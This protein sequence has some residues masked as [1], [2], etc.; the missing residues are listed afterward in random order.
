MRLPDSIMPLQR[1]E[2]A[3]DSVRDGTL[4]GTLHGVF[5]RAL[6]RF[7]LATAV[8]L[9]A[10][11]ESGMRAIDRSTTAKLRA[12]AEQVGGDAIYP[13]IDENRYE[14]GSY[15]PDF[16]Q[17]ADRP[18]TENPIAADL[19]FEAAPKPAEDA[20]AIAERFQRL[21]EEDP[22]A[23]LFGFDD[24]VA[25]AMTHSD[26][27]LSAEENYLLA[28]IRLL[29]EEHRWAPLPSNTTSLGFS[30]DGGGS[31]FNNALGIVN[32]LGISQRLPFGGEVSAAFVVRATEQLDDYLLTQDTQSAEV[33]LSAAIPLLRGFGDVA[34]EDL[35]QARRNLIYSARAFEQFRRDFYQDLAN[36]YL[37]L[38]QQLQGIANGERQVQRSTQVEARTRALVESGR[39]E[40]FQADLATQNTLFALD[41]LVSQRESYRLSVDRFKARIGMP[42]E[43]PLKIDPVQFQLPVPKVQP[44][45][46]LGLA[47]RYRL[48]LQTER[49]IVDDFARKVDVARNGLLGDLDLILANSLPTNPLEPQSGLEFAPRYDEF[50]ARLV[51]SMPLDRTNEELRLRQAQVLLEQARRG[52]L[53]SRDN[54]A[55]SVRQA[56]RGIERSLFS[57][58]V[59]QKNVRAAMNRQA[60]IDAAPDRATARDRTE[61]LD[62]LRRAQDSLDAARKDLQL[63]I[64]RYLNTTGQL[65]IAAD[66]TLVPLPGMTFGEVTGDALIDRNP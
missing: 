24:A 11:C 28:A 26:E 53:Q 7:A 38:V 45:E 51:Y 5:P 21:S 10:G 57:L 55:V 17:D 18:A 65:R 31:R 43:E 58:S 44:D 63:A 59:Q 66:G 20:A 16:P 23:K 49:D 22:N 12:S 3:H 60:A 13:D 36:D 30:T 37:T 56:A 14:S 35:I 40:P 19:K 4:R 1:L 47:F 39:T 48:D 42:V 32:D 50:S 54:A 27:Y 2:T 62:Q 61:A 33:A 34:R 25:Y 64:I 8:L 52:Y 15:F 46:A 29:L 6:P 9:A 41:R